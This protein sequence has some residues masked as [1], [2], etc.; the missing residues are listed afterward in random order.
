M[1]ITSPTEQG[2]KSADPIPGITLYR[3]ETPG[4]IGFDV[5]GGYGKHWTIDFDHAKCFA[6]EPDGYIKQAILPYS[7]KRL[8]LTVVDDEGFWDYNYPAVAE[9]VELAQFPY[10]LQTLTNHPPY[11]VWFPE[12]TEVLINAGYDSLA[13]VGF[14]GLEEYVLNP[15]KLIHLKTFHLYRY[16]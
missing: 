2:T 8:V 10:L 12:L 1:R 13:T 16:E 11:E 3:G 9:L 15:S 5:H 7:A 4:A 14:E 6:R